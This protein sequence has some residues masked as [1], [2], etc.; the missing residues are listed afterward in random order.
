MLLAL[1]LYLVSI[2]C[3]L[4]AS[5]HVPEI[6]NEIQPL[7]EA[8]AASLGRERAAS[9]HYRIHR[10]FVTPESF[11]LLPIET[12]QFIQDLARIAYPPGVTQYL[13]IPM[14]P[15]D[16][17]AKLTEEHNDLVATLRKIEMCGHCAKDLKDSAMTEVVRYLDMTVKHVGQM[18]VI[19]SRLEKKE[20]LMNPLVE[21]L[22]AAIKWV[23]DGR[24]RKTYVEI[25]KCQMDIA[26]MSEAEETP[27]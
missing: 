11:S 20:P 14:S 4:A 17:L 24:Y 13:R 27:S 7:V 5:H 9:L 18:R 21:M 26:H 6:L 1:L 15:S 16:I 22:M 8:G 2:P 23:Q 19:V 3:L 10:I 25:L 12:R